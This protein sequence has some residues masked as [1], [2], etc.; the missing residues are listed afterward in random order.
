MQSYIKYLALGILLLPLASIGQ[1]LPEPDY[2][3]QPYYLESNNTLSKVERGEA[4][5]EAKI[6]GMGYGGYEMMY[7]LEEAKSEK[8]LTRE[9]DFKFIVKLDTDE[10]PE[11]IISVSKA[12]IKKGRR[13]FKMMSR[14][15]TGKNRKSEAPKIK[16][17]VNKVR[18]NIFEIVLPS[19]LEPGEYAFMPFD[20]QKLNGSVGVGYSATVKLYCFAID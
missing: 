1:D 19:D 5:V 15:M 11:E 8:R 14:T 16:V 13:L 6:K 3:D 17:T 4:S 7:T 2:N 12:T 18:D 9:N 20:T 10:D